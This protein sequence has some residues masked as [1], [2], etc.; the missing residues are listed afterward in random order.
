MYPATLDNY[1]V[2]TRVTGAQIFVH[3]LSTGIRVCRHENRETH[4]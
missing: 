3:R 2:V 4:I 1:Q